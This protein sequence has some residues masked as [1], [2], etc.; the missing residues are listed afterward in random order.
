MPYPRL[1][2]IVLTALTLAAFISVGCQSEPSPTPAAAP[3]TIAAIPTT[4][5]QQ[6]AEPSQT[7]KPTATVAPQPSATPTPTFAPTPTPTPEPTPDATPEATPD[8]EPT[9][10]ATQVPGLTPPI[11]EEC[12][13]SFTHHGIT[14]EDPWSWLEDEDYPTVDDEDVLAYWEAENDYFDAAMAPY[15]DLIDAIF[16]E[17]EGR[18]PAELTSLPR[19]RGDWYYQWRYGEG[20]EYRQWLRWPASDPDARE[21]P[22]D[23]VQVFLDEPELAK[24]LE[25]FGVG[26]LSVSNNG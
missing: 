20:S 8:P 11:A 10:A 21:G 7:P 9:L 1:V 5:P 26:S 18:Q 3:T 2:L 22:T 23:N 14:V 4:M 12:P 24:D 16:E 25:Y 6:T 19:R 13:H 15:Q 17:I